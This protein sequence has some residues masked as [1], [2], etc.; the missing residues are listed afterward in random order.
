[1]ESEKLKETIKKADSPLEQL[2]K[3]NEETKDTQLSSELTTK[4]TISYQ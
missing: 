3:L 1:M 4:K 2:R